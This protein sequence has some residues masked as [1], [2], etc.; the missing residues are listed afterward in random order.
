Y[1]LDAQDGSETLVH[2]EGSGEVGCFD[3]MPLAPRPRPGTVTVPR[4]Y[5]NSDG[6]VYVMDVYKGTHMAGVAKGDVKYLRVVESPEK[7]Y[8]SSQ[9]WNAQGIEAP[10][11]NWDSFE[12]KRILGT[13]PV[14]PDG[15]AHFM[16]PANKFVYFQLLDANGMM[17]QSMRSGTIVQAGESQGC[18]GCH[19]DRGHAPHFTGSLMPSAFR[20]DPDTLQGW[21][22]QPPKMFNYLVEV[23]PVF[24]AKCLGC[25]DQGGS[26]AASLIL[27]AD[28]GVYFNASYAD[29]WRKGYTGAIGAGP[30][31]IQP[32][33]VWG[34]HASKLVQ[35]LQAGHYDVTLTAEEWDR[36]VTWVDLNAVYYPTY[37]ANYPNNAGGR[38]PLNDTDL[39]TLRTL[40][41]VDV[42]NIKGLGE[43]VYFDRPAKSPCLTGLSGSAY[44]QALGLIQKGRNALAAMPREDMTNCTLRAAIDIWRENKYQDR[45]NR[46]MMNRAAVAGGG[47]VYDSQPLLAVANNAPEGVDGVSAR[48]NGS[49]LYSASNQLA[50]VLIAWGTADAGE[51]ASLWQHQQVVGLAGVGNFSFTLAGLVPGQP[52][53]FRIFATN[54]LGMV[55]SH[56]STA[57]DTRSLLDLNGN[58]MAD[59]WEVAYFGGTNVPGGGP[60]EDW[61]SDGVCNLAEYVSGTNPTNA[62]SCLKFIALERPS[63]DRLRVQWQSAEKCAYTLYCSTNLVNWAE[64]SNGIPASPPANALELPG[65]SADRLFFRV[66][67]RNLER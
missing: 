22:G 43:Q 19:E 50:N 10:G 6:R 63:P 40:S 25:H 29:L 23:Q 21:Q 56:I 58:G 1:L 42:Y 14:E 66:S 39:T 41:G 37:A 27:A 65:G 26:A 44:T 30:A 24:D 47:K 11:V 3:P 46:E 55:S 13:V 67:G 45:L 28:K 49:V 64:V 54:S 7:R 8:Y 4:K 36:I 62:S 57:F 48:I 53:Y 15:S 59:S 34:S 35:T 9:V 51:N 18:T 31:A 38:S 16:V 20:R 17:I 60:L 5:D 2:D 61:D 32:P 12:T 33:R 52:L